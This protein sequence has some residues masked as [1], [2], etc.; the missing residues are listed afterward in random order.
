MLGMLLCSSVTEI[1][2]H[3]L[4]TMNSDF[5]NVLAE[6]KDPV[7]LEESTTQQKGKWFIFLKD[8]KDILAH[9]W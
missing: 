4:A 2:V 1:Y 5:L 8:S 3:S 9:I 6:Q 7:L